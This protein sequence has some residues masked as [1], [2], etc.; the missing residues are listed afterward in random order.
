MWNLGNGTGQYI[1]KAEINTDVENNCMV[2]K[3]GDSGSGRNWEIDI[4]TLPC[5][6][7]ITNENYSI[8]QGTLLNA[9]G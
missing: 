8:A 1:C 3:Q 7:Q 4:Y 6:K 9:L 5:I 2:T